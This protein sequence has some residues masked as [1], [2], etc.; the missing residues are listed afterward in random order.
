ML[1][2][3][4]SKLS[5]SV[6][7]SET[8]TFNVF[9]DEST[10]LRKDGMPY[11]I[12]GYV[13]VGSHQIKHYKKEL[14]Q[15]KDHYKVPG[16][17]K[18]TSVSHSKIDYYE[19]LLNY[20]FNS[21]MC[22][23]AV[24]VEKSKIDETRPEFTYD[25]FYF[26]MYYQLLHHKMDMGSSYNVY[27]DIKDTRSHKKLAKLKDMLHWN[28][29]IKNFQFIRSHES[30]IMQ[31]ADLLMGAINYNLRGFRKVEAKNKLIGIIESRCKTP[32]TR[33]TPKAEDKFNLFFIDL[34]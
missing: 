30:S 22:F 25:E 21:N 18:W 33:S 13:S 16:E 27:C 17:V 11:M 6:D 23:R 29:S 8:K 20:F 10:H 15:I 19:A 5:S 28:A 14:K 3:Q 4:S 7:N 24:I 34:K 1:D 2:I 9:C 32:I 26:R 31:L 12:I